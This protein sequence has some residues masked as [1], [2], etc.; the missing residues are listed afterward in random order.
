MTKVLVSSGSLEGIA[1]AIRAKN[2]SGSTYKPGQMAAAI[3]AL[4]T[5]LVSKTITSNGSY[6]PASDS[7]DGYSAVTVNV[8][9]SYAAADEGKVV[10]SGAL[11]AQTARAS[12]I[13]ANG[14]YDTTLNDEVTVNVPAGGTP[15]EVIFSEYKGQS[16]G[17]TQTIATTH[18][19]SK[20]GTYYLSAGGWLDTVSIKVNNSQIYKQTFADYSQFSY[21]VLQLNVGDVIDLNVYGS[22]RLAIH[23]LIIFL[24]S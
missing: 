1:D 16:S 6:N 10:S 14:T 23:G 12:E 2:G 13:T 11:V 18:T 15:G 4:P 19:V 9:N 7:A 21:A 22:G 20:A 8:P 5:T 24:H 17:S 3:A